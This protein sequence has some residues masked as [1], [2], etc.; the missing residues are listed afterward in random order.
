MSIEALLKILADGQF[1][2]GEELGDVLG[3]SRTAI[4]KQV[5]KTNDLGLPLESV[6]GRGYRLVGG[7]D[8]LSE[9]T[10]RDGLYPQVAALISELNVEG[11]VDSTNTLAMSKAGPGVCGYVCTAEQQIAGRGRRG[12][13]WLSPY[14]GSICLSIVWEFTGG[15]TSLEGLSL[16]VGVAMV[17]ALTKV[18]V[19]DAQLKWPNDVLHSG[20]KLS[21]VLLEISGDAQGPC[22]VVVGV[23]VNVSTPGNRMTQVDQPWIDVES[24]TKV[25]VTR[26]HLMVLMLNELMPLLS[27]F[28]ARGFAGY[29][30]RW[31]RLDAYAG[32]QV[33]ITLGKDVVV[34]KAC[35]VDALGAV[36]I[37][38]EAGKQIFNGG[39]VSLRLE[40]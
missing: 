30:E 36:I 28:E 8:L 3:V 19:E 9:R 15:V 2:S 22:R 31:Q 23:G 16:A 26:N 10:I 35:G 11:V 1:H 33:S 20:K 14:A 17:D 25:P 40:C 12:R 29:R 4:W 27:T 32:H 6:R 18:G 21:G 5:K 38:T 13:Q 37:E 34:G 7:L 39:E 24:I